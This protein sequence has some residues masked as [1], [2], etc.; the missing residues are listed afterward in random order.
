MLLLQRRGQS[1]Q[2]YA[3]TE[4]GT[5]LHLQIQDTFVMTVILR[6]GM[7]A[8]RLVKYRLG[9]N[10]FREESKIEMS[11]MK[12][13][14]LDQETMEIILATMG[15]TP[16]G[17]GAHQIAYWSSDIHALGDLLLLTTFVRLFVGTDGSEERMFVMT[18]TY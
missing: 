15:I 2:K 4:D 11:A 12:F 5:I 7:G 13:V 10:V 16:M 14:E 17:M 3:E 1:A 18:K 6:M 9:F 8:P